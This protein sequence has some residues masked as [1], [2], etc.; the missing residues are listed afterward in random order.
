MSKKLI[1]PVLMAPLFVGCAYNAAMEHERLANVSMSQEMRVV[2][3]DNSKLKSERSRLQSQ[4]S[5]VR[6]SMA[7][8]ESRLSNTP[9]GDPSYV[10][11]QKELL[12]LKTKKAELERDINALI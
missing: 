7:S 8:V 4:L 5:Q 2:S 12:Q 10:A 9:V 1:L 3:A 6:S 11:L